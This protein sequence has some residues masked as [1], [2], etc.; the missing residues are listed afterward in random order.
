MSGVGT[1]LSKLNDAILS[2]LWESLRQEW[3]ESQKTAST[4][5]QYVTDSKMWLDFIAMPSSGGELVVTPWSATEEDAIRWRD[6]LRD[7]KHHK[8]STVN[9]RLEA[10]KSMYDFVIAKTMYGDQFER[11]A[12]AHPEGGVRQN[13]FRSESVPRLGGIENTERNRAISL[14][15]MMTVLETLRNRSNSPGGSRNYALFLSYLLTD[16]SD[17]DFVTI[18]WGDFW[19]MALP[20][21]VRKAVKRYLSENQRSLDTMKAEDRLWFQVSTAGI[22]NF[23]IDHEPDGVNDHISKRRLHQVINN[24]FRNAGLGEYRK[25]DLR[26]F[27]RSYCSTHTDRDI[28]VIE[29]SL[30]WS[31]VRSGADLFLD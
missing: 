2:R 17:D 12:F 21:I 22:D 7:I 29:D 8:P 25:K 3:I 5:R 19:R 28:S 1:A 14:N 27:R 31:S 23:G 15:D 13:P 4:K 30:H 6:Y 20:D 11:L 10:C 18:T 16:I 9:R 26:F 24:C